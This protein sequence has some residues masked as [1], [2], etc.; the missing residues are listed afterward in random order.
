MCWPSAIRILVTLSLLGEFAA[1][2]DVTEA[3]KW[4]LQPK[5]ERAFPFRGN[6][7]NILPRCRLPIFVRDGDG[8]IGP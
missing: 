5:H 4:N 7:E 8:S 1:A 6:F 2:R 3:G